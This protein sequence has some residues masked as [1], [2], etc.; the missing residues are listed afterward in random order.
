[1]SGVHRRAEERVIPG[2][3]PLTPGTS[4]ER[5]RSVDM[6]RIMITCPSGRGAVPTG[7]RSGDV[8]LTI[9][10]HTRSFRCYCGQ[11]HIWSEEMAWAEQG[12]T[13]AASRSYGLVPT[14]G[15]SG[16]QPR[17]NR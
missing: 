3:L 10:S 17:Q 5:S 13:A 14:L 8:D 6:T 4:T 7:Y 15:S 12:L 11:I 16:A 1:V 2:K 9:R